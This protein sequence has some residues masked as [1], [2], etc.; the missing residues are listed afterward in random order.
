MNS[1]S[2][3]ISISTKNLKAAIFSMTSCWSRPIPHAGYRIDLLECY[4]DAILSRVKSSLSEEMMSVRPFLRAF[5]QDFSSS[6]VSFLRPSS[7]FVVLF[8]V[9]WAAYNIVPR[10]M[11]P[12]GNVV[13][14]PLSS[15]T[16]PQA[17][18]HR[19]LSRSWI[20]QVFFVARYLQACLE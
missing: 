11:L 5:N 10:P 18:F 14:L 15:V 9:L 19:S 8:T 1:G 16:C 6:L 20:L 17:V 7:R 4:G 2:R 12:G 13:F 3:E